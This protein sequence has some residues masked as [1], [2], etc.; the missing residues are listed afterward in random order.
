MKKSTDLKEKAS[1][2]FKQGNLPEAIDK[3]NDCLDIDE[4]NQTFNATILLNISIA[5]YK[6]D[7]KKEALKSLDRCLTLKPDYSKALV[8]R[9]EINMEEGNYDEAIDDFS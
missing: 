9:G 5:Q 6:L 7:Q 8:K 1:S 4:D 2:L 3:F